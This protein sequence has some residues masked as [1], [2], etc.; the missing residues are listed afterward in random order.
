MGS[1][2]PVETPAVANTRKYRRLTISDVGMLLKLDKDGLTQVEIAQRLGCGQ[3]AVSEWLAKCQDTS[4][5]AKEYLRGSA[6]RMAK[7]IVEKGQPRDHVA[8]LKGIGVLEDEQ[9]QGLTVIVQGDAQVNLGPVANIS[10]GE[11]LSPSV[12]AQALS[13]A[14]T[15]AIHSVTVER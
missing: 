6:L 10:R 5:P 3:P 13:P 9:R 4:A 14:L 2:A 1:P 12:D 11:T 7:N 15:A 8:T